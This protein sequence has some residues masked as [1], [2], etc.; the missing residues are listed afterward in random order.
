MDLI[1]DR[2]GR[3]RCLYEESIDL[4]SLGQL[5]IIRASSVEPDCEGRWWADLS[6]VGG[7][8]LGPYRLR[9]EALKAERTFLEEDLE[10]RCR[11]IELHGRP[12]AGVDVEMP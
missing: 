12:A 9:S 7:P 11:S 8:T 3:V 10:S 2:R 6:G 5:K 4:A 1:I